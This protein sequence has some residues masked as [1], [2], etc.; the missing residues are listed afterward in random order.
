MNTW[1]TSGRR[2]ARAGFTL[3]EIS[4]ALG[5]ALSLSAVLMAMLQQHLNFVRLFE[6]QTFLTN[7]AP[8]LGNLLVR[9]LNGADHFFVYSTKDEALAGSNPKLGSGQ[10]A[11]LFFKA[12][13]AAEKKLRVLAIET[14]QTG[15]V[16]LRCYAPELGTSW[17]V[18]DKLASAEF[19]AEDG[20]LGFRLNGP[21]GEQTTY[22][23]GAR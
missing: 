1:N 20:I 7:E 15:R 12:P 8:Q 9:I 10:A 23:G 5:M 6:R 19:L 17:T 11:G 2:R 16:A 13:M 14:L 18:S 22:W 3:L 4:V 21:H